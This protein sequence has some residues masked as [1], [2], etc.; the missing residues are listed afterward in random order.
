MIDETAPSF[1]T[2]EGQIAK[3]APAEELA[4]LEKPARDR[5]LNLKKESEG[6]LT[7]EQKKNIK[8][9][10]GVEQ[11]YPH[12][13]KTIQNESGKVLWGQKPGGG[14]SIIF[15]KEGVFRI[16]G[17]TMPEGFDAKSIDEKKLAE[18]VND[19][20][21]EKYSSPYAWRTLR[22]EAS[23]VESRHFNKTDI[24]KDGLG[25]G[26]RDYF[27]LA[28]LDLTTEAGQREIRESLIKAEDFGKQRNKSKEM[29]NIP[30]EDILS[31]L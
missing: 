14:G 11:K 19:P 18:M 3:P 30:V 4:H 1:Y 17:E 12:A 21:S 29:V 5:E 16:Y 6:G 25:A 15:G 28:R 2:K 31:N 7:A 9:M 26:E 22:S 20:K 8:I 27:S 10:N 13:F 24:V 23:V